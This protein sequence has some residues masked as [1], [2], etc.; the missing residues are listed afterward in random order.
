[1]ALEQTEAMQKTR[2]IGIVFW[3]I[4]GGIILLYL[5]FLA[6]TQV[7]GIL[8]PFFLALVLVYIMRPVVD[9]LERRGMRRL[10]ALVLTYVFVIVIVGVVLFFVIPLLVVQLQDLIKNFPIYFKTASDFFSPYVRV[11]QRTKID[12]RI[13]GIVQTA[14]AKAQESGL[15]IFARVPAY[16]LSVVGLAFNLVLAPLIAFYLLKDLDVIRENAMSLIPARHRDDIAALLHEI[17]C[18]LAGFLRGQSLVALMVGTAS[19]IALSILGVRYAL[20][21]GILTGLLSVI[22]YFGPFVGAMIAGIVGLFK[23]PIIGLLAFVI[24][25]A[26]QQLDDVFVVPYIMSRNVNIHPVVVVFALLLGG[27]LFG[28][29]G[30]ILAIPVAAV[31]KAVF[32]FVM[33]RTNPEYAA[34]EVPCSAGGEGEE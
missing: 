8:T 3:T 16:T 2:N 23:A 5:L 12:G 18:V 20:V 13:T 7:G 9:L 22:P 30:L 24:I 33:E 4:L 27:T 26:I 32:L 21:L 11:L 34:E 14:L 1:M 25:I 17:D 19:I 15:A 28:F 10:L 31:V 6:L 29:A